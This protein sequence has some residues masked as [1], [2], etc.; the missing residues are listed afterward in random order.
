MEKNKKI[1]EILSNRIKDNI[2][3]YF[4]RFSYSERRRVKCFVIDMYLPYKNLIEL[5][6]KARLIIDKYYYIMQVT[7]AFENVRKR[8][9]KDMKPELRKYFKRSKSLLSKPV[10][11]LSNYEKDQVDTILW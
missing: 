1:L 2:E 8:V 11:K 6:P 5:F 9:P 7:W 10:S 3:N 4:R